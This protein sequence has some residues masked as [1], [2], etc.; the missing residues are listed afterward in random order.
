MKNII[1]SAIFGIIACSYGSPA[2]ADVA[3]PPP[4][5]LAAGCQTPG[6]PSGPLQNYCA[7]ECECSA[8]ANAPVG[9][10]FY[11]NIT[12]TPGTPC[13]AYWNQAWSEAYGFCQ[14][15]PSYVGP[16][17]TSDVEAGYSGDG[18]ADW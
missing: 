17:P 1:T 4:P 18:G 3:P 13:S 10:S 11:M 9:P 7:F 16:H 5:P 6:G 12:I 2:S 8:G 14:Q 15:N